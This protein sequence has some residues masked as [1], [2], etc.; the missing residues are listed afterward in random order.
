MINS[1]QKQTKPPPI[2]ETR[3]YARNYDA[4]LAPYL[5]ERCGLRFKHRSSISNHFKFKHHKTYH[6]G[7]P[8]GAK[9]SK[10]ELK[11]DF[12]IQEFNEDLAV[13]CKLET[14]DKG[15]FT[16]NRVLDFNFLNHCDKSIKKIYKKK[17]LKDFKKMLWKKLIAANK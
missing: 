5:C 2:K 13:L 3:G 6:T 11:I 16:N 12:N 14:N 15:G 9:K 1:Q 8:R 7:R 4:S 10:Y 17:E